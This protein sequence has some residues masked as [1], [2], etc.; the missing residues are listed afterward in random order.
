M[1]VILLAAGMGKRMKSVTEIIPKPLLPIN[2]IA[3][4]DSFLANNTIG[5]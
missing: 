4:I 2:G 5:F 3:I 1:Q